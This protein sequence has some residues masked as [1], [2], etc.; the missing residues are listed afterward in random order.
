MPAFGTAAITDKQLNDIVAYVRYLRH[1]RDRGGNP[2]WYLGPLVEGGV[3]WIIGLGLLLVVIRL[4]G[5][6]R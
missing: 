2:L 3:A 1:P 5:T 4:I 6:P